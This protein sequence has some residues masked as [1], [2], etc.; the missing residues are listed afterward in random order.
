MCRAVKAKLRGKPDSFLRKLLTP[1][2]RF[3]EAINFQVPRDVIP[4]V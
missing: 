2:L 1:H 3:T 4:P